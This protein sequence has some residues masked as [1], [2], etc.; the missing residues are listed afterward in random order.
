MSTYRDNRIIV[1]IITGIL[2][3][4]EVLV[5]V[6]PFQS[7]GR[8]DR[9]VWEAPASRQEEEAEETEKALPVSEWQQRA[10]TEYQNLEERA[11]EIQAQ[12]DQAEEEDEIAALQAEL[13]DILERQSMV[14]ARLDAGQE[15]NSEW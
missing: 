9:T 13:D 8:L 12:I 10:E 4:A 6:K 1:I 3:V 15:K 11:Q 2:V 14:K 7:A 5:Y